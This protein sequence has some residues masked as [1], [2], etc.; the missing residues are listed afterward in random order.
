[1]SEVVLGT[2][3]GWVGHRMIALARGRL[4]LSLPARGPAPRGPTSPTYERQPMPG[5]LTR[6]TVV[7]TAAALA[8]SLLSTP[9]SC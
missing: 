9:R 1:M 2:T 6:A 8:L 3:N 7:S 5:P 4:L